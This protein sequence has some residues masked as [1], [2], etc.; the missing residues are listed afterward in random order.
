MLAFFHRHSQALQGLAAGVTALAAVAALIVVP[1]QI[2]ANDRST[3]ENS[4]REI[5]REFLN[6]TIQRADLASRDLCAPATPVEQAAYEGY[7]EYLLYTAEQVLTLADDWGPTLTA[8]LAPHARY[9]CEFEPA[10]F[11]GL[12]DPVAALVRQVTQGCAQLPPCGAAAA[13]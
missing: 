2:A 12:T 6:I 13:D 3:R 1:W 11:D 4:A 5:Y 8:R 9:L 10:D 7:V